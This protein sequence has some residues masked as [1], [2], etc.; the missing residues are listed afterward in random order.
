MTYKKKDFRYLIA[1]AKGVRKG[2][3]EQVSC[4]LLDDCIKTAES[5]LPEIK[6]QANSHQEEV[7][8]NLEAAVG[9]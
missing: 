3:I 8:K 4:Q 7:Y 1:R 5:V 6:G 9:P 2:T